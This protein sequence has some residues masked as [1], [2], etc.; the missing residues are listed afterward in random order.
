LEDFQVDNPS[1]P[2]NLIVAIIPTLD[3]ELS[4][5]ESLPSTQTAKTYNEVSARELKRRIS[6]LEFSD[7]AKTMTQE[8]KDAE[9]RKLLTKWEE[10]ER[11][12]KA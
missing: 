10:D 12:D 9:F 4:G 11:R 8:E 6:E 7:R 5:N 3:L 1:Y 2:G